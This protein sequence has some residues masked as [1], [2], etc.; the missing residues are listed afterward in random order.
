MNK[1][2]GRIGSL[3]V[4]GAVLG[5]AVC[6]AVSFDFGSFLICML[7]AL[8]FI[9]MTAG[10]AAESGDDARAASITAMA[11]ACV[12]AVLVLIVYF[13]QTTV[14]HLQLPTDREAVYLDFSRSGL[15]F[16]LDLLGY[17]LMALST[18]F[19]GLTVR[20]KSK[21]DRWLKALLLLHGAFFPGCFLLPM[22]GVFPPVA[23]GEMGAG[24]TVALLFWCAYF[25]PVGALAYRHFGTKRN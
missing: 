24:G 2:L 7:L 20:A 5:F 19:T 14:V 16:Y 10:F 22:L 3:I 13:T 9:M 25:L 12:Y 11:F 23:A 6:L 8:G 15:M 1:R 18:F 4:T 21:A 17:G